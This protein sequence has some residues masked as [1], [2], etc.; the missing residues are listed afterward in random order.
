MQNTDLI[1]AEN[2]SEELKTAIQNV[3]EGFRATILGNIRRGIA[4]LDG[5]QKRVGDCIPASDL[6]EKLVRAHYLS[7]SFQ[8]EGYLTPDQAQT[9]I[10]SSRDYD[11]SKQKNSE[12]RHSLKQEYLEI[13]CPISEDD[14]LFRQVLNEIVTKTKMPKQGQRYLSNRVYFSRQSLVRDVVSCSESERFIFVS[15]VFTRLGQ[16]LLPDRFGGFDFLDLRKD[17]TLTRKDLRLDEVVRANVQNYDKLVSEY[18]DLK[19][20]FENTGN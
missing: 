8:R 20:H 10:D 11:S 6:A 15:E 17:S 3:N 2:Y 9:I 14:E 7:S 1:T 13:A 16:I 18:S 4:N 19:S 5:S 12:L